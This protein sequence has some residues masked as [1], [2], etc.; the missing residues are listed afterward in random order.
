MQ[1]IVAYAY[2]GG[3]TLP[4]PA[5]NSTGIFNPGQFNGYNVYLRPWFDG[6]SMVTP[7]SIDQRV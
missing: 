3:N 2:A 5:T 4:N 1:G 6:S 7:P